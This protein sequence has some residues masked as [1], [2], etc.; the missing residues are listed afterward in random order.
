MKIISFSSPM[1]N[2]WKF[3]F[4]L[5]LI[6]FWGTGTIT[7]VPFHQ[8]VHHCFHPVPLPLPS[9]HQVGEKMGKNLSSFCIPPSDF[10]TTAA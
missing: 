6:Y 5:S 8:E 10:L 2:Q 4:P 7:S 9:P 1:P 3:P